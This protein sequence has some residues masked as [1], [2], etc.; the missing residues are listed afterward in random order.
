MLNVDAGLPVVTGTSEQQPASLAPP[1]SHPL[2][3]PYP[4][5]LQAMSPRLDELSLQFAIHARTRGLALD[6]GCGEGIA[7]L[8]A[9]ARG[10]RMVAVDPDAE[11]IQKLLTNVPVAQRGRL[12]PIV[13]QLPRVD[14]KITKFAAVH[15]AHVL[16][17]LDGPT[18]ERSLRKF[19]RWLQPDGRLFLSV[20]TPKGAFWEPFQS[21]YD[22]RRAAGVRWPGYMDHSWRDAG[23]FL[24]DAPPIHLL[25]EHVL[26]HELEAAGF[27][28]EEKTTYPLP[29]D[30]TQICCAVIARCRV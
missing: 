22:R 11:Q 27:V 14:F 3:K 20:L 24:G 21:E 7:T 17:L 2:V 26:S 28:I 19:A 4:L 30:S 23:H 29:W 8:A 18:I 15:A 12:R 6:I 9:L 1:P 10:A 16:H 5:Q 13:D 25:D